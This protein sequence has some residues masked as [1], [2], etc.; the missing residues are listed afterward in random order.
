[1]SYGEAQEDKYIRVTV[2]DVAVCLLCGCITILFLL[3]YVLF[4]SLILCTVCV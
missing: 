2:L 3:C 1:V 4:V